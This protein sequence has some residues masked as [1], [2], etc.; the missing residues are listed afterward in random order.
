[1]ESLSPASSCLPSSS[2]VMSHSLCHT[3]CLSAQGRLAHT[4]RGVTAGCTAPLYS[5]TSYCFSLN[6]QSQL[7][8]AVSLNKAV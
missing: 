5:V 3:D 2:P 1:M 6:Q 7:D 8:F 4:S